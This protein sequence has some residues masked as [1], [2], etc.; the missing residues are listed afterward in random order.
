MRMKVEEKNLK[1]S[2]TEGGKKG[3]SKVIASSRHLEVK[4]RD[5]SKRE[6]VGPA[7]SMETLG[8][9][10]RTRTKKLGVKEKARRRRKCDVRVSTARSNRVFQR[11]NSR[12]GARKLLRMGIASRKV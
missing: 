8:V 4:F 5:C 3:K 9:D 11:N 2:L 12:I 6:G 10:M 1:L 7:D